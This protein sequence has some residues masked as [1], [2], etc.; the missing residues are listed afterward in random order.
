MNTRGTTTAKVMLAVIITAAFTGVASFLIFDYFADLYD[1]QDT[2]NVNNEE[3]PE[4]TDVEEVEPVSTD[5]FLDFFANYMDFEVAAGEEPEGLS[6]IA[7]VAVSECTEES[8]GICSYEMSLMG[9][10]DFAK[11]EN[12]EFYFMTTAGGPGTYYGPF[13]GDLGKVADEMELVDTLK[14]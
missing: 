10:E 11:G 3:I 13:T 7:K 9:P 4:E 2:Q 6:E 1:S 14:M 8:T 12:Q 5:G